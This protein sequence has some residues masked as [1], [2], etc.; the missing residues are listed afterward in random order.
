[1]GVC[2]ARSLLPVALAF[3]IL[4]CGLA[5]A[6]AGDDG[7]SCESAI[8]EAEAALGLPR[9]LLHALALTE[10]GRW[11]SAERRLRPWPWTVTSMRESWRLGSQGAAAA[12]VRELIKEGRSN[13]DVGCLQVNLGWHPTAFASL[14]EAFDPRANVA[15]GARFLLQLLS[16]SGSWEEAVAHYHSRDPELGRA[17][18]ERV[19]AHWR[20]GGLPYK[21]APP[22]PAREVLVVRGDLPS[23]RAPAAP[24]PALMRRQLPLPRVIAGPTSSG[25]D[26]PIP[27]LLLVG[28]KAVG[29]RGAGRRG[30]LPSPGGRGSRR[31]RGPCCARPAALSV[32]A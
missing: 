21:A 11:D 19:L 10:S 6:R 26:R 32:R 31:G 9:G 28:K 5:T 7:S 8:T 1:L 27:G 30:R 15:Y 16:E 2:L 23:A 20:E 24:T 18:R 25:A 12:Q 3:A 4:A 17:Y 29:W 14:E 22:R 13:I